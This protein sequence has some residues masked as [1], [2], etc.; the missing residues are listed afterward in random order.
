MKLKTAFKYA[1]SGLML[2]FI[3]PGELQA[4]S[5][6]DLKRVEAQVQQQSMEHRKLQAQ[7]TQINMEL[8]SVSQEMIKAARLIQNNEEK[9]SR[10]ETQL[11]KLKSELAEAEA[12]FSEEDDNLIKT[13]AALQN[14]ALKPTE[15]LLVQPL[16]P[17]DII[18]S[19]ML[20][21]ETVPFLEENAERIRQ[22]LKAISLKKEKVEKQ[23][24][25]I[26]KQK[27]VLEKEHAKMKQLVQRKSKIRN[28]VEIRS[29]KAKRNMDKL[30]GQARDLRDLLGKLEQQ[31][32]EKKRKEEE[33]RRLAE[34]QAEEQ[35]RLEAK[36]MEQ[37]QTADL[38]K[39]APPV[40]STISG[41]FAKAKGTL[42]LPARGKIITAYGEQVVKGVTS[43]GI[44]LRTRN[45]AQVIAPF[46]G[47]VIFAG[48]FRGYGNLIIIEHGDGYLSLLAGLKNFD[49]DVGQML[50]AGEPV[51]QMP[52][53]GDAKLYVEIR[54]DNQPVDP[55]AWMRL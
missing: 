23:F 1:V 41:G 8:A 24:E 7:A 43:K 18:R 37:K 20:L 21:R 45:D 3:A 33:A 17:V 44:I 11:E 2:C 6:S 35:R 27:T 5:D 34:K 13:L 46:D 36:K 49:V 12:G 4:V 15:A 38:I 14:L 28:A 48:P 10:M 53:D 30:A 47:A 39:S 55:M 25:Q 42:P 32:L 52:E 31:R 51:G 26:S 50:L 19:A 9:L 16:T 40:I 22:E 54:K 29:E